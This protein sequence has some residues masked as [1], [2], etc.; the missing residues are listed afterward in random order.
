MLIGVGLDGAGPAGPPA[1]YLLIT[2]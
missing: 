1:L 2:I